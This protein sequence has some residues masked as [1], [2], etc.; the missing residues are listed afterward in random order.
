MIEQCNLKRS[1]GG[2]R[3]GV[4]ISS[5]CIAKKLLEAVVAVLKANA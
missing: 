3:N 1:W 4:V 2:L 5:G